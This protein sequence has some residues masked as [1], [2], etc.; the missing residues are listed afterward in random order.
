VGVGAIKYADLSQTRSKNIIF[1]WDRML[2]FDGDAAPYLQYTY[3]RTRSV[4]RK[5]EVE[6]RVS[7]GQ[8]VDGAL[9]SEPSERELLLQLA[10]Y[11]EA[12]R[13]AGQTFYPHVIANHVY[14]L[15]QT[16]SAFWRDVPVLRAETPELL[17]ARLFLVRAVGD[18]IRGGL[19]LLGIEC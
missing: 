17:E 12:V 5:A 10:L 1:E 4:L 7:P 2:D 13:E 6:R 9:L 3:A 18:T 8:T 11:P 19:S 15:S 16:F 14:R